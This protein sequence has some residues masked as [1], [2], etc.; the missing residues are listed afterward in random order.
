MTIDP[1][2]SS[3]V[4]SPLFF[5]WILACHFLGHVHR[6][7]LFSRCRE[8]KRFFMPPQEFVVQF[9]TRKNLPLTLKTLLFVF[10]SWK[11]DDGFENILK[12]HCRKPFLQL[13]FLDDSCYVDA[14]QYRLVSFSTRNSTLKTSLRWPIRMRDFTQLCNS[15]RFYWSDRNV[16]FRRLTKFCPQYRW[17]TL[18]NL[19]LFSSLRASSP[20]GDIVK[21]RR[22]IGTLA[23]AFLGGLLR[24]PN[25]RACSHASC[26]GT[27]HYLCRGREKGQTM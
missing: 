16:P 24:S 13:L 4:A 3:V 23:S 6:I 10:N 19:W 2:T 7:F 15:I 11:G 17:R 14:K 5:G 25:R 22:A 1:G 21:S 18:V 8:R 20:F 12:W 9:K 26:L 27:S